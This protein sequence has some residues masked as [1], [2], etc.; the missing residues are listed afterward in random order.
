MVLCYV[1]YSVYNIFLTE[2]VKKNRRKKASAYFFPVLSADSL[3]TWP[4][5][6]VLMLELSPDHLVIE[7]GSVN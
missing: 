6:F 7:N 5:W 3:C 4:E 2:P 1:K